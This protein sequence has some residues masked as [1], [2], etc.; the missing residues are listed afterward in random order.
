LIINQADAI[1]K[2]YPNLGGSQ[3][4]ITESRVFLTR[5][6]KS[7]RIYPDSLICSGGIVC[8]STMN[9]QQVTQ[10]QEENGK[11]GSPSL[12]FSESLSIPAHTS[13]SQHTEVDG[14]TLKVETNRAKMKNKDFMP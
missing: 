6:G 9:E 2:C 7:L 5:S 12:S 11:Q 10:E 8:T 1:D 4:S 13:S 14:I 3:T